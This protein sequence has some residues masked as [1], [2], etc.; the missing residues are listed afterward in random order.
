[1]TKKRP[2]LLANRNTELT[3]GVGLFI[4]SAWLIY[5]AYEGRGRKRPFV[6]RVL[7]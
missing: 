4:A 3:L 1:M 6:A 5:D 7:P 2:A